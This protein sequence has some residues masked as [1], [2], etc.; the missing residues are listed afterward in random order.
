LLRLARD[1][2]RLTRHG[3]QALPWLQRKLH[4]EIDGK[5]TTENAKTAGDLA[6]ET[7]CDRLGDRLYSDAIVT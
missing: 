6:A 4:R 2:R 7:V 1:R 3:G 5:K